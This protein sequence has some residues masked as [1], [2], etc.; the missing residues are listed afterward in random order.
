MH[1][2]RPT[3]DKRKLFETRPTWRALLIVLRHE[4]GDQENA[5]VEREQQSILNLLAADESL[6]NVIVDARHS[7]ALGS[8][9][10]ELFKKL[11][12]CAR[13]RFGTLI[14]CNLTTQARECVERSELGTA[15]SVHL[16]NRSLLDKVS[17]RNELFEKTIS[18]G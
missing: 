17:S 5:L 14:L 10:L 9:A 2:R 4:A 13:E 8:S 7:R 3:V 1:Y 16:H 18:T 12:E 11:R 6:Q 15:D